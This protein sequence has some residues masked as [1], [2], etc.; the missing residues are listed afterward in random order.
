[1][2]KW[3]LFAICSLSYFAQ[4]EFLTG[5]DVYQLYRAHLRADAPSPSNKDYADAM[6]YLGYVTGLWDAYDGLFIC[7]NEPVTRGQIADMVGSHLRDNPEL[8]S[9]AASSTILVYLAEKYP[10][11]KR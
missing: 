1:M 6:E 7:T 5:N 2:K 9:K 8:R 3:L 10:C 4:A 11:K